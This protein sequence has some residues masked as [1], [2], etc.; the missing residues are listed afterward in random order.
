MAERVLLVGMMGAGKS[1]VG[2][3]VAE[4][5]GWEFR[6]VDDEVERASGAA[7]AE[8]FASVGEEGFRRAEREAL[9]SCLAGT[10]DAVVSVGGGAVLSSANRDALRDAGTVV[11]LRARPGTLAARVGDGAGRPLL[12]GD[13]GPAARLEELARARA[14][15]YSVVA[16]AVV[17]VDGLTPAEVAELVVAA[18][19]AGAGQ[20]P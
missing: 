8:V 20:A 14:E 5:L 9:T 11:W 12:A 18:R 17:D 13:A 1:T 3:L 4:R 6:D 2:R 16:D 7:V 15:L 19:H 10:A